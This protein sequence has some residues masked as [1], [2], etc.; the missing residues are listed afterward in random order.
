[1]NNFQ[2][3]AQPWWVNL[4]ILIPFIAF[5]FFKKTGLEISKKQLLIV[6]IFGAAFGFVE[7][8]VVIYLR[9]ALAQ[10]QTVLNLPQNL[11]A[12]EFF[13]EIATIVILACIAL[14]VAKK[15]KE[16]FAIFIWAFA[17]WDIFYYIWLWHM[18]KWPMSLISGDVL[19]LIPVPWLSEVWFPCLIST[20]AMLAVILNVKKTAEN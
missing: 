20:L 6:G 3:F 14:L 13:R 1:M 11:M 2:L 18:V 15:F 16:Q 12:V 5:Y 19:F 4:L 10:G 9:A 17:F 8:A 7:A